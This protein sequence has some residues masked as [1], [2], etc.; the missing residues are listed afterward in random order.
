M[1]VII[2]LVIAM[3]LILISWTWHNM[4]E[5]QK[6]NK[7]IT[8]I[9]SLIIVYFITLIVFNISKNGIRYESE[10]SMNSVRNI[11]VLV[12]TIINGLIIIPPFTKAFGRI[13]NKEINKEQAKK[14]FIFLIVVFS[15]IIFMECNYLKGVQQGILDI[16]NNAVNN[17]KTIGM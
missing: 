17:S 9:I 7:I 14:H 15:V 1:P 5:I 8:I 6:K 12:F 2:T 16:Y 3:F 11:I 4:G 10:E 13:N